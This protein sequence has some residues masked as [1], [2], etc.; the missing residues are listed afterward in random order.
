MVHATLHDRDADPVHAL[1][2]WG[3]QWFHASSPTPVMLQSIIWCNEPVPKSV[4]NS[5][6]DSCIISRTISAMK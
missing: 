3:K 6:P 2:H 1:V 5:R 4:N